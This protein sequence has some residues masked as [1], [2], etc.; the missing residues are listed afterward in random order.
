MKIPI[1]AYNILAPFLYVQIT[2]E[3]K[4]KKSHFQHESSIVAAHHKKSLYI[5]FQFLSLE[6]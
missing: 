6:R 2:F 3:K 5:D 4:E 1:P